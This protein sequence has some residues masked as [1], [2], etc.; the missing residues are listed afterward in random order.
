M[1]NTEDFKRIQEVQ[2]KIMDDIHRVCVNNGYRYYL[3]GGSALGAVRHKG[4][5]PWDVD[6]DIAMPRIDYERFINEGQQFLKSNHIIYHCGNDKQFGSV[7]AVV[8]LKDSQISF[9]N[10]KAENYR[11][12]I[13]VDVL[14][15]DQWPKDPRLKLKQQQDLKRIQN[16]R[17]LRFGIMY[18]SNSVIKRAVKCLGQ[19]FLSI[20]VSRQRLNLKQ[21]EIMMRY[22]SPDEG[23][24]WCSMVSHYSYAKTT[25]HKTVFGTPRLMEFS[26]RS[27]FVPE[28]I[29]H[30][31]SQLFGNYLELPPRESR[32]RQ[33][34][35]V[36]HASWRENN[37]II[38][39]N[40]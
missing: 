36:I 38:V 20:F 16:L 28:M 32:E 11:Y 29:N 15:L 7:H 6:I 23:E 26:G 9:R 14:P 33:M 19:L 30:Y 34:N 24:E 37:T 25:F 1:I 22:D 10:E 5:I 13:F 27:F 2:L 40:N 31:L 21:Q 8:V 4:I 17:S 18:P 35:S 3:I 39:I 12:G